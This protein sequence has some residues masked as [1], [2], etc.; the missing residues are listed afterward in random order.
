MCR[1]VTHL[2]CLGFQVRGRCDNSAAGMPVEEHRM[3]HP[4]LPIDAARHLEGLPCST[5]ATRSLPTKSD[6]SLLPDW[7]C[8]CHWQVA[9]WQ[10]GSLQS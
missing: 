10:Q 2:A 6:W 4:L 7:S 9:I 8:H 3:Q 1:Q 5:G